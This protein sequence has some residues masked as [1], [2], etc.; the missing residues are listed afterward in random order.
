MTSTDQ[1][2]AATITSF[3][4]SYWPDGHAPAAHLT[5]EL[6]RHHFLSW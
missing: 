2:P 1:A 6:L 5:L 4:Y 3:G